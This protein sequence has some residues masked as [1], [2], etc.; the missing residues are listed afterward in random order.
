MVKLGTGIKIVTTRFLKCCT[1]ILPY[2]IESLWAES[3]ILKPVEG[4][5]EEDHLPE[6]VFIE[7]SYEE[8]V[9]NFVSGCLMEFSCMV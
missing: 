3:G 8:V 1:T 4:I 2:S 6:F 7:I 9:C 5:E